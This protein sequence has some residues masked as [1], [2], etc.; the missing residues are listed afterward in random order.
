MNLV[1][2]DL[3]GFFS[4]RLESEVWSLLTRVSHF[5]A[6]QGIE[7]YLVGGLVRDV[8][9]GRNTA[10]IDIAVASDA[11]EVAPK[12]ATALGG[13]YVLLDQVNRV[14]RV[15]LV[16]K[17]APSTQVQ[18]ELDFSTFSG[19]IESDLARRDFTIDAMAVAL[20]KIVDH[21]YSST[22]KRKDVVP[23]KLA[24]LI[25]PF[26]GL[27]DLRQGVVRA[28]AET[29]FA[30][31]A[32]RLIRAV[33]LAT[34]LGFSIAQDTEALMRR[35][36]YLI[37]GIAGERI[38]EE[39]LRLLALPRTGQLWLYLD[40][41]GLLTA[42]FPEL[43]ET[44][45]VAQP[46]EHFWDVFNHSLRT[47]TAVDFLLRQGDWEY[48]GEEVL[49]AVPWSAVLAE[50]FDQEVSHGS[51]R[52]VLL[53]LAALLHDVAKP[54]AKAIDA[55]GRMRFLGHADE[56]AAIVAN[57]LE[58]LRFS[59]KEVKLVETAVRYHLRPGQMSQQELPTRRAIY[60]YFRDTGEAGIDI[61][62]LS[63]ADH[64]ASRGPHLELPQWQE[65]AQVVEYVLSQ[66]FETERSVHPPRLVDGHDLIK[67]LA[68]SPGPKIGEILEAVREAQAS[69][70]VT[71]REEAL[72]FIE[73]L[74]KEYA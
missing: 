19:D 69:G 50:H 52:R 74:K 67:L 40:G 9:L 61:L 33:R 21:P 45:G 10:D 44:K 49:A 24:G 56:G 64:L 71:T 46:K 20:S 28:V 60:R 37:G 22:P 12:V 65:H 54:Q 18:W 35:D 48:A 63:L 6:E 30:S 70:E 57:R 41:L 1:E 62:F 68:L 5:F 25:D 53:K 66:R 73:G 59:T 14:G 23:L 2:A 72:S 7:A 47:V 31:D 15:V 34:E 4:H 16:D 3:Q 32:V 42:V 39:L 38:R 17:G 58:R 11:L 36:A 27:D 51:T 55:G 13:K 26:H 29:V 8:L 43:A